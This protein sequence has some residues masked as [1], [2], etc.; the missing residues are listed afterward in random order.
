[1]TSCDD[2]SKPAASTSST[3][4]PGGTCANVN[5]PFAADVVVRSGAM[6]GMLAGMAGAPGG[7]RVLSV[8][9]APAITPPR[10]LETLPPTVA[11]W[12]DA[13]AAINSMAAQ[14]A[15]RQTLLIAFYLVRG[16]AIVGSLD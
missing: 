2:R 13:P 14:V 3:Y 11:V 6:P 15:A 16:K 8:T 10:A 1:M 5:V 12:A 7:G 9:S 4:W